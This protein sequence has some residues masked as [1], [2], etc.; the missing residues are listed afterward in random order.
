MRARLRA[1]A[2]REGARVATEIAAMSRVDAIVAVLR[3]AGGSSLAEIGQARVA[4][5]RPEGTRQTITSSFDC[6]REQ[7]RAVRVGR[8]PCAV[9]A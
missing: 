1:A 2:L 6:P 7:D 9:A 3:Q 4:A 5:G 8:G